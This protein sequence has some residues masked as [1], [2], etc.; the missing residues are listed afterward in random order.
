MV[1]P[2][3]VRA[4]P[5]HQARVI[6]DGLVELDLIAVTYVASDQGVPRQ[7]NQVRLR[8]IDRGPAKERDRQ[9]Q[10]GGYTENILHFSIGVGGIRVEEKFY[11]P[12]L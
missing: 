4:V 1:L 9:A 6:V 10:G 2:G 12:V 7:V 5:D 3:A 11:T 8:A